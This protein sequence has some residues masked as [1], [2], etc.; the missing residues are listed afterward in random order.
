[1]IKRGLLLALI[2]ALSPGWA[3][4]GKPGTR[5]DA[6]ILLRAGNALHDR[7]NYRGALSNYYEA[8]RIFPSYKIDFNIGVTLMA[9]GRLIQAAQQFERFLLTARKVAEPAMKRAAQRRLD[10]LRSRLGSVV[11]VCPVPGAV[12]A[13]EGAEVGRTPLEGR[14]YLRPGTYAITVTAEGRR[15]FHQQLT[16]GN[17]SLLTLFVP[18]REGAAPSQTVP[19]YNARPQPPRDTAPAIA[20][21]APAPAPEQGARPFYKRWWFWTAVG[22]VVAGGVTAAVVVSRQPDG[23]EPRGELGTIP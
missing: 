15:P 17:G 18:W 19:A 14:L 5:E 3:V 22:A 11:V 4:A 13:V 2:L 7:G 12:V 6:E 16:L 23:R 9:M 1:M 20:A 10:R 8:R 21:P